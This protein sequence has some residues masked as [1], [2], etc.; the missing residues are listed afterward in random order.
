MFENELDWIWNWTYLHINRL[1]AKM[2]HM[3]RYRSLFFLDVE[4]TAHDIWDTLVFECMK[5]SKLRIVLNRVPADLS[6]S[7][8]GV[9]GER[10]HPGWDASPAHHMHTHE[11]KK[12]PSESQIAHWYVFFV[13]F[14][15]LKELRI[16]T[17]ALELW[18]SNVTCCAT[19]LPKHQDTVYNQNLKLNTILKWY[20]NLKST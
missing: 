16:E 17:E 13:L 9:C 19:I 1:N 3:I 20:S 2:H 6:L 10:I 18:C 14:L 4:P 7:C 8:L 11:K 12:I 15:F 5:K